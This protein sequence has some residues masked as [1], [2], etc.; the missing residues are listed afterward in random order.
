MTKK[1]LMIFMGAL[2][3]ATGCSGSKTEHTYPIDPE[4][5][6]RE[7]RGHLASE[8]GGI[9]LFGGDKDNA[10]AGS[11]SGIGVNSFLW[12]ATLDTFSF[13]PLASADPFG[14]VIITDWYEDPE[15]P[16]ERFKAK[17]LILDKTLRSDGVKVRIFKQ[18]KENGEWAD[19]KVSDTLPKQLEDAILTRARELRIKQ[20][21]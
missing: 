1:T 20:G 11:G 10:G 8:E 15:T 21:K 17:V 9:S 14:G 16:G 2:V 7:R 3:L 5:A 4:D 6:R 19:M 12:R 13:M 18:R